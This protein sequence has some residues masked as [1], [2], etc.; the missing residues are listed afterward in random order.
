MSLRQS[1]FLTSLL[2]VLPFLAGA[3][4][5]AEPVQ[6]ERIFHSKHDGFPRFRIPSLVVTNAGVAL[7]I[8]EGRVDGGGLQG[9]VD[10]VLRRST[11][12]G[13]SWS[14]ISL[15]ANAVGDTLG[16]P[17]TVVDRVTGHVW[18]AFT[19]S[20]GN[21]TEAQ[22]TRGESEGSTRVFVTR[23][24]DDGRSWSKPRDITTT[25]KKKGWTWYGT[26]PGVGIQL[27]DGRLFIPSYHCGGRRRCLSY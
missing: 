4:S 17:C 21:F 9:N 23:S 10:L 20:P 13:E 1:C 3:S 6:H 2:A 19:R 12:N 18:V 7:S 16:N 14:P 26:G 15:I 5:A 25:T 24:E 27:I 11:D 22:I 8:C